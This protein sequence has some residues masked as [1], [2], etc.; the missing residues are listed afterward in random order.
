[1]PLPPRGLVLRNAISPNSVAADLAVQFPRHNVA[2]MAVLANHG[3]VWCDVAARAGDSNQ[4]GS[5]SFSPSRPLTL[6]GARGAFD[7]PSVVWT[8]NN[9]AG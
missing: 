9:A 6:G 5:W 4:E 2:P 3:L 7:S 1:M 8:T